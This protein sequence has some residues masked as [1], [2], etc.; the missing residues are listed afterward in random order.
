MVHL[1]A[2]ISY[3][4]KC[5]PIPDGIETLLEIQ[6]TLFRLCEALCSNAREGTKSDV[7]R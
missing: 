5:I 6:M 3:R 7:L 4:I 2:T 1:N